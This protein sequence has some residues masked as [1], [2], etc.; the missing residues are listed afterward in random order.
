MKI[1]KGQQ[2]SLEDLVYLVQINSMQRNH[3]NLQID[4]HILC[5]IY[6][7]S[8]THFDYEDPQNKH[9]LLKQNLN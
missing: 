2:T 3:Q 7:L 6:S 4:I 1:Q 8:Q 9:L 5:K